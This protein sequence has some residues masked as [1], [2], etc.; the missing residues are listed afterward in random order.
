MSCKAVDI[1]AEEAKDISAEKSQVLSSETEE[2]M[3]VN[4]ELILNDEVWTDKDYEVV[5]KNDTSI[6]SVEIYPKRYKLDGLKS[7]RDEIEDYF[8]KRTDIIKQVVKC[9]VENYGNNVKLVTEVNTERG[10]IFF[11]C[12]PEKN[13]GDLE[14]IR[15]VR[16]SCL[17]LAKCDKGSR[18]SHYS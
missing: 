13:Y 4:K 12:D 3:K 7:F 2:S 15:T 17:D 10:W 9:E 6:C 1:L 8:K 14:G 5:E 16:H 11:F 18:P